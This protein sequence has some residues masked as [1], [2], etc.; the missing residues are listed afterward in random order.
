MQ[1][2]FNG[3]F[4]DRLRFLNWAINSKM[5]YKLKTVWIFRY[6]TRGLRPILIDSIRLCSIDSIKAIDE[7]DCLILALTFIEFSSERLR[8]RIRALNLYLFSNSISSLLH[9]PQS[10]CLHHHFNSI[11]NNAAHT[12]KP[13]FPLSTLCVFECTMYILQNHR[14][15]IVIGTVLTTNATIESSRI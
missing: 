6:A 7:V 9:I 11:T 5:C 1:Y 15:L 12:R 4:V 2:S 13:F 8:S 3:S 10:L 14:Q